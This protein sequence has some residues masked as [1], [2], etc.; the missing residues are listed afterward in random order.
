[1]AVFPTS[2]SVN[3]TVEMGDVTYKWNGNGWQVDVGSGGG[4][5]SSEWTDNSGVLHPNTHATDTVA[6]GT[7][8]G[9]S[10]AELTIDGSG[11]FKAQSSAPTD[12]TG[13]AKIYA[14]TVTGNVSNSKIILPLN[15]NLKDI[16]G[17]GK[18]GTGTKIAYSEGLYG[19][20]ASFWGKDSTDG[21]ESY[22][23]H[24]DVGIGTSDFTVEMF[25]NLHGEVGSTN[26]FIWGSTDV[27]VSSTWP[28]GQIGF[29]HYGGNNTMYV[30]GKSDS[31]TVKN[32][33][34]ITIDI[35]E[36]GWKHLAFVRDGTTYSLFYDGDRKGTW[37]WTE[38]FTISGRTG[39]IGRLWGGSSGSWNLTAH[40]CEFS[41]ATEARYSDA[42]YTVPTAPF[43]GGTTTQFY[44]Q[45]SSG[46]EYQLT[47]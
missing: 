12:T 29:Y 1:M 16:S 46:N 42:T 22:I 39:I 8:T 30:E 27:A 19:H 2:P 3:Q 26:N 6:I 7:D 4:G 31:G 35:E 44:C 23:T 43:T 24:P 34:G 17:N 15:G 14:K 20:G 21:G 41:I 13:Y 5:G 38:T 33:N 9:D 47:K 18:H 28:T 36:K 37:T 32:N 25:I 40:V 45:D 11:S 10:N